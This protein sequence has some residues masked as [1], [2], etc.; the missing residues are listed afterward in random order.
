MVTIKTQTMKNILI[1][2]AVLFSTSAF[3]Q[4]K[5]IIVEINGS[6]VTIRNT[7]TEYKVGQT[8]EV[9]RNRRGNDESTYTKWVINESP[10]L[11]KNETS[12]TEKSLRACSECVL[13]QIVMYYEYVRVKIKK[14]F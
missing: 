13:G 1:L 11:S 6:D 12:K 7:G 14:V 10:V 3:A 9:T 8:I 5:S 2:I 4:N